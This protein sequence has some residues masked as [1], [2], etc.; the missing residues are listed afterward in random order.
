MTAWNIEII[1]GGLVDAVRY[2]NPGRVAGFLAPDL[3]WDGVSS[4]LRCDGREQA[5]ATAGASATN[6]R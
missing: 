6:W 2:R 3:V 4:G 5:L 1:L